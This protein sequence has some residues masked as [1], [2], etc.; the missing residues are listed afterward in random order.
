[1]IGQLLETN[2]VKAVDMASKQRKVASDI[3]DT[4]PPSTVQQWKRMVKEWE[5]NHSRPNPYISKDRGGL[6]F[7]VSSTTTRA[8]FFQPQR[9][10]K[11]DCDSPRKR[12]PRQKRD[13]DSPIKFLHQSSFVMGSISK[14]S[15]K[16]QFH[17]VVSTQPLILFKK[18][19]AVISIHREDTI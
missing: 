10:P 7:P 1:V 3:T 12:P 2:L 14:T 4:F 9:C 15:S 5:A 16:S 8:Y 13:N 6:F 18:A 11:S 19:R 17:A